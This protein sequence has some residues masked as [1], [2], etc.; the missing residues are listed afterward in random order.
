MKYPT[1]AA[2]DPEVHAILEKEERRQ[3]EGLEM[4]PSENY[5]SQEV[6]EAM[7]SIFTNKYAEGYP[8]KRYYGG[9]VNVDEL[10]KLCQDRALKLFSA[11]GYHVNVQPYSGSPANLAVYVG[12][13]EL[14]DKVMALRL[15][16]GGHITHGL[17]LS[18]SGKA[19]SFIH[20]EVDPAT[21]LIDYD[22]VRALALEHKPKLIVS[23]FTA[24][25]RIIDFKRMH[26]IAKEVGAI[27]M[28]DMS[29]ISG[30]VA[31]GA[32][33]S[34]FPFTDIV[35][36]TT[37]KTLRGPR[38]A[39]IFCK[40]EYKDAI[41]RG[42]FPGMQGGP[43]EHTIAGIA[44]ALREAAAPEFKDYAAQIVENSK[45]LTT[46]LLAAGVKLVA[47]GSE[48]HLLLID[49]TPFGVGRGVFVE[50]ALDA[51]HIT[52]NK[53]TVPADPSSPFYPSG[54]RLG[55]PALT[56][57][58]MKEKEMEAIGKLIGRIV[59]EFGKIELPKGKDE[60]AAA[61]K[62]FTDGLESNPVVREVRAKVS[63]L[64]KNFPVPGIE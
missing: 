7:G 19:F 40:E 57:R 31:G 58:G 56:T 29:H 5:V 9:C 14:G 42:V 35:T 21:G 45:A 63:E 18:L 46:S 47:G 23:G 48:N 52:V 41:N 37:H 27:S 20:Y 59:N 54:V 13:L 60:R 43:H 64:T 2:Q 28:A 55:T 50:K 3:T 39:M 16:H 33:P 22:K 15:D 44:A 6:L 36:T 8:G 38:A 1:L 51:A 34:P 12:L 17:P 11:K 25:S 30:L 61:I 53:N 62:K 10:E 24:Y 49:L 4:I 32:H 26:E